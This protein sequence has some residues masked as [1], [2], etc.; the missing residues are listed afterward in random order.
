MTYKA[1]K[2]SCGCNHTENCDRVAM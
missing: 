2:F 1:R